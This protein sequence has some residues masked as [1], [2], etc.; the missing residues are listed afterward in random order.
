MDNAFLG[1]VDFVEVCDNM[2]DGLCGDEENWIWPWVAM[3]YL[4]ELHLRREG[5]EMGMGL[6]ERTT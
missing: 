1:P 5:S 4:G 3:I 6:K 2:V